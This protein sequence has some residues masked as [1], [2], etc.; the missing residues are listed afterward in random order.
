MIKYN[1]ETILISAISH[2]LSK[3]RACFLSNYL[4]LIQCIIICL[5]RHK[6]KRTFVSGFKRYDGEFQQSLVNRYQTGN[7]QAELCRE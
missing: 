4:T 5:R 7:T 2:N 1:I 3:N 6:N